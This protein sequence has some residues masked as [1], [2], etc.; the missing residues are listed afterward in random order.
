M[1]AHEWR[2]KAVKRLRGLN[3]GRPGDRDD[4]IDALIGDTLADL[5]HVAAAM[6]YTR[7]EIRKSIHRGA[8]NGWAEVRGD[9]LQDDIEGERE[10]YR[11]ANSINEVR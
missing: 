6:G 5:I 7:D 3:L 4:M 2:E 1:T 8:F 11:F 9:E 10:G